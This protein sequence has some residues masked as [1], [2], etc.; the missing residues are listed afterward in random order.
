MTMRVDVYQNLLDANRRVAE[1]NRRE[2]AARGIFAVNLIGSPGCGKT[3]LLEKTLRRLGVV[4]AA[5]IEGDLETSRD[6][7]RIA[8]CGVPAVQINTSGGCHL[9]AAM[10][11][12]ALPG[13]PPA[14]WNLLF[15]EN[16]GNL[17]CPAVYDLG[18]HA[19]VAVLSVAE[20]DDK[21]AKYP[22][23]FR[24]SRA[25]VIAKLDLLPHCDFSLD[26][27]LRD[28]RIANPG[29]PCFPLSARTGEGMDA[30]LEWLTQGVA[31]ARC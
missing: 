25:A 5:V 28:I 11:K 8:K 1:E 17:V 18:E 31:G 3:T 20:G 6:A 23:I 16:V 26:A 22:V 4:R 2:F 30:W 7:E 12:S 27:A 9:D 19:K 15:I 10:V 29:L 13:L 21:P 14:G 24:N